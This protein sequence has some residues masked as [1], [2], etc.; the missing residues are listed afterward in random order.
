MAQKAET[1]L[2]VPAF[3]VTW[4]KKCSHLQTPPTHWA[5][6]KH[7]SLEHKRSASKAKRTTDL[8]YQEY[9]SFSNQVLHVDTAIV[10]KKLVTGDL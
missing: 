6:L 3:Q 8:Q 7:K 9:E 5:H 2:S 1:S 4:T 10:H